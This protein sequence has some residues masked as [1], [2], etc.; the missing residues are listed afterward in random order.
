[1]DERTNISPAAIIAD[2][3][4]QKVND[5]TLAGALWCDVVVVMMHDGLRNEVLN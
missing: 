1:M 5:E 2:K 3:Q 4:A